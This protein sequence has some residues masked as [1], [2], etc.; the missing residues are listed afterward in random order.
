MSFNT[1]AQLKDGV[2]GI[3]TGIDLNQVTN[4]NTALQRGAKMVSSKISIPEASA[5][6]SYMI[7]DGVYDYLAP[8]SIFGGSFTDFRPQG[9][10]R[11]YND[12]VYRKQVEDFDRTKSFKY[13]GVD[14]TFEYQYGTPI[15]RVVS[16][17]TAQ[18]GTLDTCTQIGNW[19]AGGS[20]STLIVDSTVIYQQPGALLFTMAANGVTGYIQETFSNPVNLTSYQTA[21]VIFVAV[22]L[23][24]TTSISSV[25]IKLGNNSSNYYQATATAS[26]IGPFVANKSSTHR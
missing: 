13:N 24:D 18:R 11:N 8:A 20:A 22:M 3:L 9:A 21:G 26:M 2:A 7:Y 17:R 4:V 1:V 14:V 19:V 10:I 6:M 25:T 16:A 5:R 12:Y 23:P 15:L